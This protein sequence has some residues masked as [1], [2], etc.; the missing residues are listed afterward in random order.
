MLSIAQVSEEQHQRL[1]TFIH[2]EY[3]H[4]HTTTSRPVCTK[5]IYFPFHFSRLVIMSSS[6]INCCRF[7][8]AITL[9]D[10]QVDLRRGMIRPM[11]C[12]QSLHQRHCK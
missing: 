7:V 1:S 9:L 10:C 3:Q 11:H 8:F 6:S 4:T 5:I 2:S 12:C